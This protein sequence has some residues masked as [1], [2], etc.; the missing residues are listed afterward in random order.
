V[1]SPNPWTPAAGLTAASRTHLSTA[2][3]RA[4]GASA[5]GAW[6]QTPISVWLASVP[7]V[8]V[9]RKE[10]CHPWSWTLIYDLD[11][12]TLSR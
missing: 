1:N 5:L 2:E 11:L 8:P 12:R 9:L 7:V 6:T 4:Q 10:P 3:G